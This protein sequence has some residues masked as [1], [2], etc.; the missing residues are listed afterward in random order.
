MKIRRIKKAFNFLS[1][2][3][4]HPQWLMSRDRAANL[5]EKKELQKGVILDLG[6]GNRLPEKFVTNGAKYIG[7][8]YFY[9]ATELYHSK[10]DVYA[11]AE[12]LPFADATID[13]VLLLDVLEHLPGPENC[14]REIYRVLVT[15][16]SLVI[17]VPFIYPIHDSPLDYHRWTQ[18]GLH[19]L[20]EKS[21]LAVKS[22]T[23]LGN[24]LITAGLMMNL[25]LSKTLINSVEKPNP[26]ILL[27]FFLP[28]LIP[29]I[30]LVCYLLAYITPA[31]KCMPFKYYVI[32]SKDAT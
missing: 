17:H 20:I 27:V 19:N 4:F 12:C 22:E 25:S 7:V 29:L 18:F 9:T 14:L 5:W 31:D 13:T 1:S 11:N 32:A 16:G 10:P 15:G 30:N 2:T 6:C 21:G 24:P 23:A 28:L 3:P 8:D 26:G